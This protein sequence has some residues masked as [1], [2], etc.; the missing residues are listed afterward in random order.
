MS[1]SRPLLL[2]ILS[3]AT[4]GLLSLG[5]PSVASATVAPDAV[6]TTTRS[7]YTPV[8]ADG[9]SPAAVSP[10]GCVQ[11]ADYPHQST[12]V[13]GTMNGQ[14][15]TTCRVYV[16]RIS[17]TAQMWE[18]RW[19]GWDRIGSKGSVSVIDSKSVTVNASDKCRN[20]TVRVTGSGSVVDVDGRTYYAATE[21]I[22]VKNPCHL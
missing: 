17:E 6:A 7:D 16:P 12:H 10:S 3:A 14:V 18:T 11:Q 1:P 4:L 8:A 13:A 22:H 9:A 15:R 5:A 2:A 21:S 19:W 20:N